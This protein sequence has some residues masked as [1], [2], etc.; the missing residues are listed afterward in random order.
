MEVYYGMKVHSAAVAFAT[1]GGACDP[2]FFI[3]YGKDFVLVVHVNRSNVEEAKIVFLFELR[4]CF[5]WF[6]ACFGKN[7]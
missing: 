4:K 2:A 7:M 1:R 5:L 6:L 3:D